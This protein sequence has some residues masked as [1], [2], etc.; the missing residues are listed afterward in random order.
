MDSSFS[1]DEKVRR[2]SILCLERPN[3]TCSQR[4]VLAELLKASRMDVGKLVDFV[5]A[6]TSIDP[7]VFLSIH[8]PPGTS[9]PSPLRGANSRP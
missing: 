3:V 9:T 4:Y 6:N 1:D 8:L 2:P 7:Q 5:N